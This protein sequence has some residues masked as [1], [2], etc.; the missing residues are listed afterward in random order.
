MNGL[1]GSGK[2]VIAAFLATR[3]EELGRRAQFFFFR[4]DDSMQRSIRQCVLSLVY[5]IALAVP[6]YRKLL[7]SLLEEKTSLA[8]SDTR[9]L[10]QRL[11]LSLL[12]RAG[13]ETPLVWVLDAL[14][15]S[16]NPQL[17]LSLLQSLSQQPLL[18][19]VVFLTRPQS[20]ARPLERFK[21][22]VN[23]QSFYQ[24][25]MAA[26]EE[27][28]RS[29]ISQEL[30]YT[31]WNSDLKEQVTVSLLEKSNGNFLW[32]YLVMRELLECDTIDA[33]ENA[34]SETPYELS[35]IYTRME[36][37]IAA[38]L[39]P[40]DYY[41]A[42]TLFFWVACSE[43]QLYVDE[44][45]EALHP[46]FS[47]LD[48]RHTIGRL[49]GDFVA[50]DK[51]TRVSMVHHTAKEFLLQPGLSLSVDKEQAHQTLL[52][53]C[54]QTLLDARFKYRLRSN[55]C[56]G[57]LRYA[58]VSWS[59]HLSK[60]GA[61]DNGTF[62]KL[63]SFLSGQPVIVWIHAI[64]LIGQLR[65]L[66]STAKALPTF[67]EK[68]RKATSEESPL[69]Q[70]LEELELCAQWATELVRLLGKFGTHLVRHP[71][72]I[73]S[74]V[75]MFCPPESV[76]GRLF[77]PKNKFAPQITGLSN[78]GW[79]DC[80]AK[81]SVGH[82]YQP[83]LVTCL[84][85][86]FG[87]LTTDETVN[88]YNSSTF[89]ETRKFFH[90]ELILALSFSQD[91]D[92]LV[93]CGSRSVKVWDT[94]TGKIVNKY[95][96]P[97]GIRAISVTFSSDDASIILCGTDS[98]LFMRSLQLDELS[99]LEPN[100]PD[101]NWLLLAR[102]LRD[103]Y[104]HGGGRGTPICTS[105]SPDGK[106]IALSFRGIPLSVW[107]V[108]NGQLIGR[109]ERVSEKGKSR[110]DLWSYAQR[111]KWN[112]ITEHVV[113]I[114]NDGCVFKWYPLE[115]ES[116]EIDFSLTATEIACSPDGRFV[117][118]ANGSGSLR[119]WSFDNFTL[120]YHLACISP[121]TDISISADGRRIYDL[122]ESFCN[123]W[124]P[125]A[126]I[127]LAEAD[128][129]ASETSSSHAGSATMSLISETSAVILEPIGA[130][131]ASST[132]TTYCSGND[133]GVLTYVSE[134]GTRE[135]TLG[136]YGVA[137]LAMS[138]NNKYIA[139]AE[140]DGS[141]NI[142]MMD[143]NFSKVL[144]VKPESP[145]RQLLFV[146]SGG[147]LLVHS[148]QS[149]SLWSLASI[150]MTASRPFKE[151]PLHWIPDPRNLEDLLAVSPTEVS[152]YS[153]RDLSV[154]A[155]QTYERKEANGS[156]YR[157]IPAFPRRPSTPRFGNTSNT[158]VFVS[159]VY[160]APNHPEVVIEMSKI[161]GNDSPELELLVLDTAVILKE[162]AGAE[163]A[164][165]SVAVRPLPAAVLS[166]IEIPLGLIVDDI[167]MGKGHTGASSHYTAQRLSLTF[168]D[169][170]FWVC[171][172]P[173][174]DKEGDAVRR[175]FFLPR[176]WINM[177][178][179]ELAL[180][181]PDGRFLCPRNGEVACIKNAFRQEWVD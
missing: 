77:A 10:W 35:E 174:E 80:L 45:K 114:Y 122:R 168:I 63:V 154:K 72:A 148:A 87:I 28:L 181:T 180:V 76:L 1:P 176:D 104:I 26:P 95:D 170:E 8:K 36:S 47:V 89:Q 46:E 98:N 144:G 152:R 107:G 12:P 33:V 82:D 108:E 90:D 52:L 15:E 112:P 99:L 57:F 66:S 179:L 97:R 164:S 162:N 150:T 88:L 161:L 156:N 3:L 18:V 124:E 50:I 101:N 2:S 85:G 125:N 129:K 138:D 92:R 93:T 38:E 120:L 153:S 86:H 22:A 43:R 54:L 102:E 172:W 177:D 20:M 19:R 41:L 111:L 79:D 115:N 128:E 75:L 178:C 119:V 171:S 37:S 127:R 25:P 109:C 81:F 110:K 69:K 155:T 78:P 30:Q 165:N 68:Q 159:N 4:H 21:H 131:V 58:C 55:G 24:I 175:H 5:Q 16:E 166:Q 149:A 130:L 163:G 60:A 142:R 121:V 67:V 113:G 84:E 70:P 39:R 11:I 141:V 6:S 14:D 135:L 73:Y 106:Q 27:S 160:S 157:M 71:Q 53:K 64:G 145:V 62:K 167:V 91:G 56:T 42:R 65:V 29:Y 51:T 44:L 118:T 146:S 74:I 137:H 123:V 34:L 32:L 100:E 94:S 139:T 105:F 23:A 147:T 132:K 31:F 158:E 169:H 9:T 151:N 48:L 7:V 143:E 103:E 59:Y 136:F 96:N 133:G 83:T 40:T 49:C 134:E 117:V 17:L 13:L 61:L 116:E 140:W 126:L 173:M